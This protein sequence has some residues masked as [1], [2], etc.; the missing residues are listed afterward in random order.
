MTKTNEIADSVKIF[1]YPHSFDV[2][3]NP[4]ELATGANKPRDKKLFTIQSPLFE[5]RIN[6]LMCI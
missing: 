4:I 3:S 5:K 1:G 6:N 2:L